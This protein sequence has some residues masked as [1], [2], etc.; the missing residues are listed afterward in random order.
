M[1]LFVAAF[2]A[3]A[4]GAGA[5]FAASVN[6]LSNG[7]FE[8]TNDT[9]SEDNGLSYLAPCGDF[10]MGCAPG[11]EALDQF[12]GALTRSAAE[13][14][15]RN[16]TQTVHLLAGTYEFGVYFSLGIDDPGLKGGD[17]SQNQVSVFAQPTGESGVAGTSP[18]SESFDVPHEYDTATAFTAWSLFKGILSLSQDQDV[19][20]NI[21]LQQ[22]F[23]A[24]SE[25]RP[26]PNDLVLFF[27]NAYVRSLDRQLPEVP[28]PASALLLLGALGGLSVLRRKSA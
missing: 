20:F 22:D 5:S 3:A 28:L 2:A 13:N 15:A 7:G 8:T 12:V 10:G 19:I 27:D 21:S 26:A 16:T 14:T 1:K 11:S 4:L 23:G 24:P 9:W 6:L 17:F 18:N 25:T